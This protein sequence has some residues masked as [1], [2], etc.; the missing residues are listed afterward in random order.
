M[1]ELP[2]V[3][4]LRRGLEK[5]VL[6]Q[7]I[8]KVKVTKPKLVSGKGTLR[9]AS[10]AKR[11][12]F[13]RGLTGERFLRVE[14]RAKNLIFIF[15]SGKMLVVH[16]KMSGQFVYRPNSSAPSVFS[17]GHPIEL[18]ETQLPNKHSH[19]VFELEK[20]TLYYNDTRMFGYLLYYPSAA[21][22]EIVNHFANIGLEPFDPGFTVEYFANAL[23]AKKGKLKTV[24]MNQEIVTGLGNIYADE[25]AFEAGIKP[26]RVAS[27]LS[28]EEIKKLHTVIKKILKRAIEMGGSSVATYRLLDDTRGN[29]AREHKVYGKA[30]QRCPVCDSSLKNIVLNNRTTVFCPKCQ[31]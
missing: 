6:G 22:F 26:T 29:Y 28:R 18:S 23:K 9:V 21:A 14:R 30:G 11:N 10:D 19:V 17:G 1:P 31:K 2:E 5:R 12:E 8:L 13:I 25:A 15:E 16:L 27:S 3:E 24:L 4:N 20:G 7:K